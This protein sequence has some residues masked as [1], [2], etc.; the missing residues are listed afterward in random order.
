MLILKCVLFSV[1][2]LI[3]SIRDI[4]TRII[5]DYYHTIILLIGF[6]DFRPQ[7]SAEGLLLSLLFL[8]AAIATKEKGVGGADVKFVAATGFVLGFNAVTTAV[9]IG[10]SL[11]LI[12]Y[13]VRKG[14]SSIDIQYPILPFLSIGC[15]VG[16]FL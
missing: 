13:L 6:I 11:L 9:I 10:L 15:F 16:I 12:I 8:V 1:M 5:P 14:W 2:L 7:F 4:Q 3:A